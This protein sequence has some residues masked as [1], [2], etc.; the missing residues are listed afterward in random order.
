MKSIIKKITYFGLAFPLSS[1]AQQSND[2]NIN[3]S[4]DVNQ[5]DNAKK[6]QSEA[7]KVDRQQE[8]YLLNLDAKYFT[9]WMRVLADY[10]VREEVYDESYNLYEGSGEVNF[11]NDSY[12][13]SLL[14]KHSSSSVLNE[15]GALDLPENRDE[16]II[17]SAEP[18]LKLRMGS[19]DVL[20]LK[21]GYGEVGYRLD[22]INKSSRVGGEVSWL[23]EVSPV[24]N[25]QFAVQQFEFGF[26]AMPEFDY[27]YQNIGVMYTAK[28][29]HL[30]YMLGVGKNRV[31]KEQ[32]TP[33]DYEHPS[34]NAS[35][36]YS[37]GNHVFN[38]VATQ[39]ITDTT[40]GDNNT[41]NLSGVGQST[42]DV[43]MDLINLKSVEINWVTSI[44]CERCNLQISAVKNQKDYQTTAEDGEE[45]GVGA[46]FKYKLTKSASVNLNVM[47]S[48]YTFIAGSQYKDYSSKRIKYSV[49]YDFMNGVTSSLYVERETRES[50][51]A[52]QNYV[53]NIVGVRLAYRF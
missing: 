30:T 9:D 40:S 26:D 23:R 3:L 53:E 42:K 14:L 51:R 17:Y 8:H 32:P 1:L 25:I 19:S 47:D 29:K 20:L 18:A 10:T 13:V 36:S 39:S 48:D 50:E 28:L 15:S 21:A 16:R 44:V 24:D 12:P 52:D 49:D 41:K 6:R 11:G 4:A 38:L 5:T 35:V 31:E 33:T 45:I 7:E 2:F 34:Y 27:R 22:K 37:S 43:G 46:N